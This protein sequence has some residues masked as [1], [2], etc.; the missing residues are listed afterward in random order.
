MGLSYPWGME[1]TLTERLKALHDEAI[2]L[3]ANETDLGNVL[4]AH[5]GMLWSCIEAIGVAVDDLAARIG[6]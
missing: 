1:A 3:T 5:L 2:D 6:N 4:G